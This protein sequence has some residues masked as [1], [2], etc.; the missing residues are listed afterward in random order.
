MDK[1]TG[2]RAAN[3]EEWYTERTYTLTE[4]GQKEDDPQQQISITKSWEQNKNNI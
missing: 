1:F 3:G 4:I 2:L